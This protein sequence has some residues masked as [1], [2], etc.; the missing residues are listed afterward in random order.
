ML[1]KITANIV[2]NWYLAVKIDQKRRI[3]LD[4]DGFTILPFYLPLLF[5]SIYSILFIC[6]QSK[7][8]LVMLCIMHAHAMVKAYIMHH[9]GS[10]SGHN[11]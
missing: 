3:R 1:P 4:L 6:L 2:K 9:A 5:Y 10:G 11:N 7:K 8:I